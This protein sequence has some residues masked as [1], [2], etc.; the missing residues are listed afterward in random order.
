MKNIFSMITIIIGSALAL[1]GFIC[2]LYYMFH[3]TELYVLSGVYQIPTFLA[4]L[5][6]FAIGISLIVLG[7]SEVKK[8]VFGWVLFI[9]S[10]FSLSLLLSFFSI[11]VAE[12]SDV[13]PEDFLQLAFGL[14]CLFGWYRLSIKKMVKK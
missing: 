5:F 1:F 14:L 13:G 3:W 10:I 9:I 11:G 2:S 12:Y 4:F 7:R 6:S 8:V